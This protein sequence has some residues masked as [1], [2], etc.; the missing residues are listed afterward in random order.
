MAEEQLYSIN[1]WIKFIS[2]QEAFYELLT[3]KKGYYLPALSSK[4]ITK[5]YLMNVARKNVFTI[6]KKIVIVN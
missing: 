6:E 2:N 1:K 5:S 3:V 4:A